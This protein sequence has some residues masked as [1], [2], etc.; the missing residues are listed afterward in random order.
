MDW[1]GWKNAGRKGKGVPVNEVYGM[2]GREE[3]VQGGTWESTK[4]PQ[5]WGEKTLPMSK[6]GPRYSSS[7]WTLSVPYCPTIFY[8]DHTSGPKDYSP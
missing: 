8:H 7:T 3:P 6:S 2:R 1:E 5:L 4:V